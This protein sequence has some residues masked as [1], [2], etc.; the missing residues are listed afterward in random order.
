MHTYIKVS[1]ELP[2]P[3]ALSLSHHRRRPLFE[4]HRGVS[5][6]RHGLQGLLVAR[7]QPGH[8]R[9]LRAQVRDATFY[10]YL[11]ICPSI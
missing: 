2:N 5:R 1:P 9:G 6:L 7:R 8:R 4:R 11:S 10:I 3:L